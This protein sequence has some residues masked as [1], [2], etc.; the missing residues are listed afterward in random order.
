MVAQT[1]AERTEDIEADKCRCQAGP[2]EEPG[3]E[4][5]QGDQVDP[6]DCRRIDPGQPERLSQLR[7]R[8]PPFYFGCGG[9]NRSLRCFVTRASP[10]LF[11]VCAKVT[12]SEHWAQ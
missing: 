3:H 12:T 4:R 2:T 6:S 7:N 9:H 10:I 1:N 11:T 8:H 5:K